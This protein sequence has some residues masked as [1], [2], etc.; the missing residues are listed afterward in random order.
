MAMKLVLATDAN[1]RYFDLLEGLPGVQVVPAF[2]EATLRRELVDADA[3]YGWPP[4]AALA[5]ARR[6]RWLQ[7]PSAGVERLWSLAE[8]QQSDVVV[9]N[10][11]GAHAPN[12]AE[13]VFGLILA[14]SR[15]ILVARRFQEERRWEARLA[16]EYCYELAGSTIGIVGYGNI[17][18]QV[19]RRAHA[20]DMRIVAVDAQ[21]RPPAPGEPAAELSGLDG[22]PGLLA[23]ADVVVVCAP[24][25][26]ESRHMIGPGEL[27]RMRRT[28]GL[29]VIS[30]GA[31]VDHAAL[32]EALTGGLIAWAALDATE[33]EPLPADSPLWGI[34][35]CL[36]TPHSSGHSLQKERR[37][38]ELLRE[39]ARRFAAGE[40]LLNVVDKAKGY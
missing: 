9:T 22:L 31:L 23:A 19:A 40:P 27:R 1:G 20:F 26:P 36:I 10:A 3:V 34:E 15:G 32:A 21:P 33:P 7:S 5:G 8:L 4:A 18:R 14:F 37:V 24:S 13:H 25:T 2:D 29:V 30:R 28:A 39:N 38:I 11:R 6:L 35:T 17:G 12:M 16:R